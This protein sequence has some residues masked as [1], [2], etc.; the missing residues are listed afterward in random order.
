M[1]QRPIENLFDC[2][3]CKDSFCSSECHEVFYKVKLQSDK[4]IDKTISNIKK[5]K[6]EAL[7]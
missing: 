4:N 2:D 7:K 3:I 1:C 6:K 5:W